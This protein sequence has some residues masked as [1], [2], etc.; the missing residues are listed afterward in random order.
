LTAVAAQPRWRPN[1][2][3]PAGRGRRLARQVWAVAAP[4]GRPA[5][6]PA[7]GQSVIF[8]WRLRFSSFFP[9]NNMMENVKNY[10]VLFRRFSSHFNNF[11]RRAI[12]FVEGKIVV[13]QLSLEKKLFSV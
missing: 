6:Q 3:P 5:G 11:L 7:I 1:N 8:L 10:F 13:S 9:V 12:L 4:A 2:G